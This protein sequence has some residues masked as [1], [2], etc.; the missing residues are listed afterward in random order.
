MVEPG[1][2]ATGRISAPY[3]LVDHVHTLGLSGAD[4]GDVSG[5]I[6]TVL[7]RHCA[8]T[9]PVIGAGAPGACMYTARAVA[10]SLKFSIA[11]IIVK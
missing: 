6:L 5:A 1:R 7:P 11:S 9:E 8:G 3:S 10:V 4:T 2:F